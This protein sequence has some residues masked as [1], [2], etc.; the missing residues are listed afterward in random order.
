MNNKCSNVVLLHHQSP[1]HTTVAVIW[2]NL[3]L[4]TPCGCQCI[5]LPQLLEMQTMHNALI[6]RYITKVLLPV[7][8]SGPPSN[9]Y[10]LYLQGFLGLNKSSHQMASRLIQSCVHS[11]PII[12]DMQTSLHAMCR[13]GT[14]LPILMAAAAASVV[15]NTVI[16]CK[17]IIGLQM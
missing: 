14:M 17:T 13:S 11:S 5:F 8:R 4:V 12:I 1:Q 7:G 15:V 2:I 9:F 16:I 6:W 3:H 10:P